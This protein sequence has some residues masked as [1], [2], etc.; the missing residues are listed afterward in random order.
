[1]PRRSLGLQMLRQGEEWR[2]MYLRGTPID[3]IAAVAQERPQVVSRA[4]WLAKIPADIQEVIR[5]HP[6]TFTTRIL[7]NSFAGKRQQCEKD[8]FKILREEVLRMAAGG[9]G[10]Q[11]RLKTTN[12]SKA[13]PSL[14]RQESKPSLTNND[15]QVDPTLNPQTALQA[16]YLIK[17]ALGY[18]CRV[19]FNPQGGGEIRIFFKNN[20]ELD[21]VIEM[22][23]PHPLFK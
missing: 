9:T 6:E 20:K 16:E 17:Q 18:H 21:G 7:L 5:S 19:A 11:P 10:T 2:N 1:M 4:V 3:Q 13:R 8:G 22:I 15:L 12:R 14:K 23:Q